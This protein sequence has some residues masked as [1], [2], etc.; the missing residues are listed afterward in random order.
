MYSATP[1]Y[2]E[3]K[4]ILTLIKKEVHTNLSESL[5]SQDGKLSDVVFELLKF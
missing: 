2:L 1:D 4:N 3:I 5:K